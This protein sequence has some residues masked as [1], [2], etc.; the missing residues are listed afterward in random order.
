MKEYFKEEAEKEKLRNKELRDLKKQFKEDG[1]F[2]KHIKSVV[3]ENKAKIDFCNKN[4]NGY[5]RNEDGE[6]CEINPTKSFGLLWAYFKK[7][8]NSTY[9]QAKDKTFLSESYTIGEYTINLYQGQG[10][11][12]RIYKNGRRYF[13]I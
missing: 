5:E 9:R 6:L 13:Q 4:N 2:E 3:K 10:C 1:I 8:G 7:N 12:W 11:F